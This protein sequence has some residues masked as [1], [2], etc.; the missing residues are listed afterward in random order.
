VTTDADGNKVETLPD[1][2]TITT[3]ANDGSRVVRT[4]PKDDG[5]PDDKKE[6]GT[7]GAGDDTNPTNTNIPINTDSSHLPTGHTD[8]PDGT[9]LDFH[10]DPACGIDCTAGAGAGPIQPES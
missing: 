8:G 2:T 3:D 6:P 1:G 5:N 7:Q 10:T 4:P 9:A